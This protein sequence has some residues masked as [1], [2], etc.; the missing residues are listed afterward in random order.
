MKIL[1]LNPVTKEGNK[2]LRSER[3]QVLAIGGTA[4]WPPIALGYIASVLRENGLVNLKIID[5]SI[6][7]RRFDDMIL[8]ILKYKPDFVIV[9]STTPTLESDKEIARRVKE[10]LNGVKFA[11]FGMHATA[12]P[13]DVLE[14]GLVDFAIKKEPE[15]TVLEL[16]KN[17]YSSDAWEKI[18]GIAYRRA[19]K[20]INNPDREPIQDLDSIPFPARDLIKNEL[21]RLPTNGEIFTIIK[22]SRGCPFRC[23]F[24]TAH[25]YYG[26]KLRYRSPENIIME[27]NEVV[28]KFNIRNF[29][30]HSDTFNFRKEYVSKLCALIK[31]QNLKIKWMSNSRVDILSLK[32]AEEMKKAGCWL[33][34][35]GTESGSQMILDK[36]KKGITLDQSKQAVK[37]LK[38]VDIKSLCYFIFGLPGESRE[39]M[40]ET[41]DFALKLNPDYTQFWAATPF[42]GTEFFNMAKKNNWIKTYDWKLY[43]NNSTMS[44]LSYPKLSSDEISHFLKLAYRK[45]YLRPSRVIS[46]LRSKENSFNLSRIFDTAKGF[47]KLA[48]FIR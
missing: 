26:K 37:I 41:I 23:T 34:S 48:G 6:I 44:V 1:L 33:V 36:T 28:S 2:I 10:K 14:G 7:A 15:Y 45:F 42:P 11:F 29:L 19:G 31:S 8:E 4:L 3:C 43:F 17:L 27:I 12:I 39:T 24:C 35:L 30:F 5:S 32:M 9:Q 22:I 20:I 18:S 47:L 25:S 46:H 16:C 13:E 38:E 21:Y 40:K